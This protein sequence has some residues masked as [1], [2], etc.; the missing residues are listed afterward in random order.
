MMIAKSQKA[1]YVE[2]ARLARV[3]ESGQI[4]QCFYCSPEISVIEKKLGGEWTN[5]K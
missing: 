5:D 3:L 4:R 1:L 2:Y